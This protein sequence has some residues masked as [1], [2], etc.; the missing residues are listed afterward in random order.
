MLP[1]GE[2][3]LVLLLGQLLLLLS[4]GGCLLELSL[5]CSE[6]TSTLHRRILRR[7]ERALRLLGRGLQL[8]LG[9]LLGLR[10]DL[11]AIRRS[12]LVGLRNWLLLLLVLLG[13]V[14][15]LSWNRLRLHLLLQHLLLKLG[16]LLLLL[17]WRELRLREL[18]VGS[19]FLLLRRGLLLLRSLLLL[20]LLLLGPRLLLLLHLGSILHE[21]GREATGRRHAL[22]HHGHLLGIHLHSGRE[23]SH[24]GVR[25]AGV[26]LVH[27]HHH[28]VHVLLEGHLLVVTRRHVP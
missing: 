17:L 28:P 27:L 9:S 8:I 13:S 14:A 19:V 22:H 24:L 6:Q 5:S 25:V 11:S 21:L 26:L 7:E 18:Q 3:S 4:K 12:L 23:L 10:R 20:G 15:V 2:G 1:V 16:L